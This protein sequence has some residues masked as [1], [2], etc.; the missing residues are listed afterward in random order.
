MIHLKTSCLGWIILE[1]KD[2]FPLFSLQENHFVMNSMQVFVEW[3]LKSRFVSRFVVSLHMSFNWD[4]TLRPIF[5]QHSLTHY[6][7][8]KSSEIFINLKSSEITHF[9]SN[10]M[11]LFVVWITALKTT[12]GRREQRKCRTLTVDYRLGY[13]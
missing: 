4:Q 5:L 10:F 12:F 8:H 9:V 1:I 6:V 2:T 3:I 7:C 11:L 13:N